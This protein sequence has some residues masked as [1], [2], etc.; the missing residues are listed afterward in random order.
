MDYSIF[1]PLV[2]GLLAGSS[3]IYFVMKPKRRQ[4]LTQSEPLRYSEKE[5][6]NILIKAGFEVLEKQQ[7][8]TVM[9]IVDGKD[10]F[11]FVEADYMVKKGKSQYVVLVKTGEGS[12]DPNE[13]IVR[14]RL[15]ELDH[16]F[17]PDGILLL[18][19]NQG[20]LHRI[21]FDFPTERGMEKFF[22]YFILLC[23]VILLLGIVWMLVTLK[24]I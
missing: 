10:H 13:P 4:P 1:I 7:K 17:S 23:F 21:E 3:V 9:T 15:I 20:E 24:L 22:K 5:A 2:I 16:V 19:F 14:R 11:G 18:D 12:A 8:K 6:E